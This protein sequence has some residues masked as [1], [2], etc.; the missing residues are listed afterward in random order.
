ML[1][2]VAMFRAKAKLRGVSPDLISI[3]RHS[4]AGR[5]LSRIGPRRR[6]V[7][8]VTRLKLTRAPRP[9]QDVQARLWRRLARAMDLAGERS[10]CVFVDVRTGEILFERAAAMAR[11]TA[12][13]EKLLTA[14]VAIERL[15]PDRR[16]RTTVHAE[17]MP[18]AEGVLRGGLYLR[19]E[20]DPTLGSDA[21]IA[22]RYRGRGTSI[23]ELARKLVQ[24]TNLR[25]IEGAIVG[26]G[27]AFDADGLGSFESAGALTADL[28]SGV[29][30]GA[31]WDTAVAAARAFSDALAQLGVQVLGEPAAAR[32][33]PSAI[34]LTEAESV[35]LAELVA[36]MFARSECLFAAQLTKLLGLHCEGKA[37]TRAGVDVI[38]N[39]LSRW[40]LS[41]RVVDGSGEAVQNEISPANLA[42]FLRVMSDTAT[43]EVLRAS[44]PVAG[45]SGTLGHRMRGTA[46]DGRCTAKTGTLP[47]DSVSNVAGWCEAP[48]GRVAF[49]VMMGGLDFNVAQLLQDSML[50]A[51]AALGASPNGH[52]AGG[53]A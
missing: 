26:D 21:V 37:T 10:G 3:L 9:L 39:T 48:S 5:A 40:G 35:P 23:P 50:A 32:T 17:H 49:A 20:G 16:L 43:G 18:D 27:T 31:A 6:A 1:E 19:G 7:R 22:S 41:A 28:A 53:S 14:A 36:L 13:V 42:A 29:P 30:A 51:M 11:P 24:S 4:V 33:P 34:Q 15:G 25:R 12:S 2:E 38:S 47:E 46:A 45:R 44:L 8:A 52:S